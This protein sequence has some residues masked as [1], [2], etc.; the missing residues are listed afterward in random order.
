MEKAFEDHGS[1]QKT[2]VLHGLGGM[3]KT[4]LAMQFASK[5]QEVYSAVV[6]LNGKTDDSLKQGFASLAR[7]LYEEHPSSILLRTA[8]ETKEMDQIVEAIKR[9]FSIKG[10]TRWMLIFDNVDNPALPGVKDSQAC[11]IKFYIP[12]ADQGSI[13]ITTRSSRLQ[14]GEMISVEK[15]R[16]VQENISILASTSRRAISDQGKH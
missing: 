12:E 9:W 15:F 1:R 13:L 3:G 8:A 2:V 11:D 14:I 7:R 10:N 4:Q 5:Q 16:D 6:W